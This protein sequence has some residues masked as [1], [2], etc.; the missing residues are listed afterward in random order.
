MGLKAL[1]LLVVA[2]VSN[3]AFSCDKTLKV[4]IS[5]Q[6]APY[7]FTQNG[8]LTG[9]DIDVV[10]L[11]LKEAGFC[12]KYVIMPSSKRGFAEL[13]HGNVDLL[14]AAS[15]SKE[16]D[17]FSYFSEPYRLEVMRLFWYPKPFLE[18]LDLQGLLEQQQ[19]ILSNSGSYYG[20]EFSHFSTVEKYKSQLITVPSLR[21]RVAML[22]AKRVDFFIDDELAGLY[23]I[24][25]NQHSG[26]ALHPYIIHNNDVYLM[27]SKV[28]LDANERAAI[29]QAIVSNKQAIKEII[30]RYV[31][32]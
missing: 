12:A 22:S 2:V 14:P 6:W 15:Y 27:L 18:K 23:L 28:T 3:S 30:A 5:Q 11:V 8:K 24:Q 31:T 10:N 32:N 26:I 1:F 19:I 7:T 25:N 21:Q 29:S 13:K 17:V 16:R 9:I 4:G 20:P